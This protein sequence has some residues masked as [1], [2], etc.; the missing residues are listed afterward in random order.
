SRVA[1]C[2]LG[3]L[4]HFELTGPSIR[5]FV[6]DAHK[7]ADIFLNVPLDENTWKIALLGVNARFRIARIFRAYDMLE[8]TMHKELLKSK[9]S[10]NG[11]QGLLQYFSLVEGCMQLIVAYEKM[12]GF[13]YKWIVRTRLDGYWTAPLPATIFRPGVYTVPYGYD[14]G[15]LNDRLGAGD[16]QTTMATI[17]R[18]SIL[19]SLHAQGYRNIHSERVFEVHLRVSGIRVAKEMLPFCILSHRNFPWPVLETPVASILSKGP[20]NGAYCRPCT[21][22][23]GQRESNRIVRKLYRNTGWWSVD[24]SGWIPTD[25]VTLELCDAS[26]QAWEDG[27]EAVFD[28]ASGR[29]AAEIRMRLGNASLADCI[30]QNEEFQRGWEIWD[31]MSPKDLCLHS[32]RDGQNFP[33]H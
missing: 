19:P 14:F 22:K 12:H 21:P 7:D 33:L 24:R 29:E 5:K 10:P 8:S 4:R 23:A 20:L 13:Q 30:E 18:L 17:N 9:S 16:R 32:R 28:R 6:I 15:G 3:Q 31:G 2:L 25:G 11:V 1:I 27:W 26:K